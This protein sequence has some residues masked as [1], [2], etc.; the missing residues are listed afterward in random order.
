MVEDRKSTAKE[1][2][3]WHAEFPVDKFADIA[4]NAAHEVPGLNLPATGDPCLR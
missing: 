4:R 1:E 2:L 3:K